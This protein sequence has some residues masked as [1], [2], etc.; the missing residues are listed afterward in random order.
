MSQFHL[1]SLPGNPSQRF[2][3]VP[4][5]P[6]LGHMATFSA[7]KLGGQYFSRGLLERKRRISIW[8]IAGSPTM[9]K[10][11]TMPIPGQK[12]ARTKQSQSL[13]VL[14][15]QNQSENSNNYHRLNIMYHFLCLILNLCSNF[16]Y[17][18]LV[19]IHNSAKSFWYQMGIK[20]PALESVSLLSYLHCFHCIV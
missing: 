3:L 20:I 11:I 4:D 13:S 14:F 2:P 16:I 12:P 6:E 1:K 7:A 18:T 9:E 5:W 15:I 8:Q 10:S 19:T 17:A